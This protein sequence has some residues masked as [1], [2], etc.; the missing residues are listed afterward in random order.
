M[1]RDAGHS[2]PEVLAGEAGGPHAGEE[3]QWQECSRWPARI[4]GR[5]R[6]NQSLDVHD[7]ND[8]ML[9]GESLSGPA[10]VWRCHRPRA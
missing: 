10:A 3:G 2:S 8:A 9:E 7:Q 1:E 4:C 5:V 6:E